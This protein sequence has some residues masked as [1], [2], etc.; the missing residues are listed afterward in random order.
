MLCHVWHFRNWKL[1]FVMS[2]SHISK[3]H[4]KNAV[5]I[6]IVS[7]GYSKFMLLFCRC[8]V[9]LMR[10]TYIFDDNVPRDIS[11]TFEIYNLLNFFNRLIAR[12]RCVWPI[13]KGAVWTAANQCQL[14]FRA[15]AASR[16]HFSSKIDVR[17]P[18]YK[19]QLIDEEAGFDKHLCL[20]F[21]AISDIAWECIVQF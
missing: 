3:Q 5:W 12:V 7:K 19:G 13:L 17:C 15:K 21:D 6:K 4:F 11:F 8:F 1:H 2:A 14:I 16:R 18:R 20:L 10:W 9:Q